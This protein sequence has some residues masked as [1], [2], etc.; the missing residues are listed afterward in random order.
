M[1]PKT[2]KEFIEI[3]RDLPDEVLSQKERMMIIAAMEFKNLRV[4]DIMTPREKVVF[5]NIRDFLG[6]LTLDRLYRSGT[7]TFPVVDETGRQVVGTISVDRLNSLEIRENDTA[8][9][10]LD[11][12]VCYLREDYSLEQAVAAFIRTHCFFFVVVNK[13]GQ[14]VGTLNYKEMVGMIMGYYPKDDFD[15][16]TSLGAVIR[17]ELRQN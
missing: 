16:D 1:Q 2:L 9:K 5:V 17:R 4:A 7:S 15:K 12:R 8:E 3:L 13:M 10:Y 11:P 6:P 14:L